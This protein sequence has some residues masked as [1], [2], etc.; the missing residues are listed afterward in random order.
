MI[1]SPLYLLATIS[2]IL[3][4]PSPQST[5]A[6]A[7]RSMGFIG[8]SMAE[9]VA[10]GYIANNGQRM[11]GPY[12]TGGAV[13]QSWT[14]TNSASWKLFDQQSAKYNKPSAVWVQICIFAQN[15]AT[16]AEVKQLI[17]NAR[18]HSVAGAQI[19]IT[20]QP[21]YDAGQTCFLAGSSGPELTDSL[22]KQA[23]KDTTQNVTYVGSFI[24]HNG[25]VQDGCHANTA[26]QSSLGKQA[27]A[28]WG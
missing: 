13:V 12:G 15:G 21:L 26:G 27:I 20:G 4:A 23:G 2:T 6:L 10:Q 18:Q 28:F 14:N 8:C 9:N 16:Y 5:P 7:A 19:Y 1:F 24:L 22:A 17:A 3:A 25:E 11:W